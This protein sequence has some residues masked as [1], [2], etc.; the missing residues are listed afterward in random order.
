LPLLDCR[1]AKLLAM[2]K[3]VSADGGWYE[4]NY[5]EGNKVMWLEEPPQPEDVLKRAGF[6]NRDG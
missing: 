2:T 3:T 5:P 1:V 6:L 4:F